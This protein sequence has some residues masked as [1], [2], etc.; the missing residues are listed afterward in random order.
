MN[1]A[2]LTLP[3]QVTAS[4]RGGLYWL[5]SLV[6]KYPAPEV[7]AAYRDGTFFDE[8]HHA[9]VDTPHLERLTETLNDLERDLRPCISRISFK[10]LQVAYT[11]TF[12]VGAPQPPCPPYEGHY[13]SGIERTAVLLEVSEFYK[14]FG[15]TMSTDEGKRELPDHLAAELQFLSFLTFK[16]GQA[17]EEGTTELLHGYLLAQRDFLGRHLLQWLPAF[18]KKLQEGNASPFYAGL[19]ELSEELARCDFDWLSAELGAEQP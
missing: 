2:V 15:L 18:C 14:H 7:Y 16:E 17:R 12:D 10:E 5:L 8:L 13:R 4:A 11:K 6:F 9:M 19:A 3:S 1:P